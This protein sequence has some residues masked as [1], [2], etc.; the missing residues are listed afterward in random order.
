MQYV[1]LRAFD[2]G[3][4][5]VAP[6]VVVPEAQGWDATSRMVRTGYLSAVRDES[7]N[8]F[9]AALVR[10]EIPR[11]L[12]TSSDQQ[13]A[14]AIRIMRGRPVPPA[15]APPGSAPKKASKKRE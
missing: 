1:A 14:T 15:F 8:D 5:L 12:S 3:G 9:V 7:V 2:V 4:R 11:G 10:G 6:G 13:L